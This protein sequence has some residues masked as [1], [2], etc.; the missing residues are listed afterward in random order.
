M[1]KSALPPEEPFAFFVGLRNAIFIMGVF[2]FLI[3]LG[4]HCG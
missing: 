1:K 3:W 2:Y 4:C